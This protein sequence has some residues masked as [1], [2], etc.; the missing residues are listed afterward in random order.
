MGRGLLHLRNEER[1]VQRASLLGQCYT[2]LA[3]G[4]P[5]PSLM[6]STHTGSEGCPSSTMS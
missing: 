5:K 3:A 4:V 1:E 6:L 2:E